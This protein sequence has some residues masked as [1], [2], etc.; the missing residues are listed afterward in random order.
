MWFI[1]AGE[2]Y[3]LDYIDLIN[4]LLGYETTEHDMA[5]PCAQLVCINTQ[6]TFPHNNGSGGGILF[7][8]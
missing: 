2:P 8:S 1:A 4:V 6:R 3:I 7:C 5:V